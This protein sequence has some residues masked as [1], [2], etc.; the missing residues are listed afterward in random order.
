[1]SWRQLL[2]FSVILCHLV[3]LAYCD[4]NSILPICDDGSCLASDPKTDQEVKDYA[5][6]L[7]DYINGG[8]GK[9]VWDGLLE[10]FNQHDNQLVS[11]LSTKCS[12]TLKTAIT[13]VK[14]GERQF[15]EMVSASAS[16]PDKL[17]QATMTSLGD[18]NSC[19]DLNGRYCLVDVFP[20]RFSSDFRSR[21]PD[22]LKLD[23]V[24]VFRNFSFINGLC[25]PSQCSDQ[26]VRSLL[27]QILHPKNFF[28]KGNYDCVTKEE[29]SMIKRFLNL[30]LGQMISCVFLSTIVALV[31][32]GSLV[33]LYNIAMNQDKITKLEEFE[34][35]I[36][37]TPDRLTNTFSIFKNTFRL[38]STKRTNI[39]YF[40]IDVYKLFLVTFGCLGHAFLCVEIPNSYMMLENQNFL[41]E[42]FSLTK[43][44]F[45]LN[46][47]GLV[48][49][50]HLGGFTTFMTLYPMITKNGPKKF[51][52]VMAIVDRYI[53]FLPSI[54]AVV[55]LEFVWPLMFDGPF[56]KR[57]STFVL[58]KCSRS[59]WWNLTF[60]QNWFPV[61]DICGGHT[62]FSA[63]D[64]QLFILGLIAMYILVKSVPR[65]F[66]FCT[67]LSILAALRVMYN[68][69]KFETTMTMYT[70]WPDTR[71]ILEYLDVIHMTTPIYI[72]SYFIGILNGLI[73]YSGFRLPVNSFRDHIFYFTIATLLPSVTFFINGL[74][75]EYQIIPHLFIPPLIMF[76]RLLQS[77]VCFIFLT[78]F[79][80]IKAN[81]EE[82]FTNSKYSLLQAACRLS[83]SLYLSNYLVVKTEFFTSRSLFPQTPYT[84]ITRVTSTLIVMNIVAFFFHL[85]IVAPFDGLRKMLFD[86][87]RGKNTKVENKIDIKIGEGKKST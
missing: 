12:S 79:M 26:E 11:Q 42:M 3:N 38:M 87:L 35:L 54:M 36:D 80:S 58:E 74:Y 64:M 37:S 32:L 82:F 15:L 49:F 71:K 63:V 57:V 9:L 60:V 61:L 65:G 44:Q 83:Y 50:A 24:T 66:V 43:F 34:N 40:I 22:I 39:H 86:L 29:N 78:Y 21:H 53:R 77:V 47:N 1:M 31:G 56:F 33:H 41:H 85:F 19:L 81:F 4:L 75:N 55:A 13:G 69:Y 2:L 27:E 70:P 67:T 20:A 45:I 30:T 28:L 84:F 18:Y 25:L 68:G 59:W 72:P 6:N 73:V 76:N 7:Y 48:V 17:F 5:S 16:R 23:E 8:I 52:Y 51:P 46:D 14:D 62:F 10:Q